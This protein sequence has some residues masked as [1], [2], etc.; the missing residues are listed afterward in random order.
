MEDENEKLVS[1]TIESLDK[2]IDLLS[3]KISEIRQLVGP[4]SAFLPDGSVLTQSIHGVKYFVDPDDLVITPQMIVYRQWEA[5]LSQA[6]R[7]ICGK[8]TVVVDVGAN[9]GYFSVLAANLIGN[10]GSGQIYAFEPNPKLAKLFRRNMEINWSIAPITLHEA[11]VTDNDGEVILHVP[12]SHGANASLSAPEEYI[13]S[14]VT[15]PA[16]R[17]DDAIPE[18]IVVDLIK[19]DVE[20][21]EASVLRGAQSIIA[22]SPNLRLILE[23]SR[24]QME[25]AEI[26]PEEIITLLDGF[27]PYRIEVG[28]GLYDHPE[29]FDWLRQQ[30][31]TDVLFQRP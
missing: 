30:D 10:I 17:L 26:D 28:S 9:F 5:D 16:V 15:V 19:I 14:S 13:C 18:D 24:K 3:E 31:Y 12:E 8:D 7:H 22:R 6:F 4:F 21:H 11:A 2:K 23:W 29:T 27:L 20:G 1:P 25:Q